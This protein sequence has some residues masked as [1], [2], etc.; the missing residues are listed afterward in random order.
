[1]TTIEVGGCGP[2]AA[3]SET[4]ASEA[5]SGDNGQSLWLEAAA[6]EEPFNS[7]LLSLFLQRS[8]ASLL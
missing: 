3:A 4:S 6:D 1:M 2:E 5:I 8:A 7:S